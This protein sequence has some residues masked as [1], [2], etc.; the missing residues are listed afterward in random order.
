MIDISN[1]TKSAQTFITHEKFKNAVY[2]LTVG[3]EQINERLFEAWMAISMLS[4]SDVPDD[5]WPDV[6]AMQDKMT[7]EYPAA[8]E[9]DIRTS[10][11]ALSEAEAMSLAAEIS[12]MLLT[13]TTRLAAK[14]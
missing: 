1:D 9:E 5:L 12:G 6:Q 14:T 10:L 7:G 2:A 8:S 3:P 11:R 13:C 4:Q